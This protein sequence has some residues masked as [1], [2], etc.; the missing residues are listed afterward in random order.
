VGSDPGAD[1]KGRERPCH[2]NLLAIRPRPIV[3]LRISTI[4]KI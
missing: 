2:V 4:A 1:F 3:A